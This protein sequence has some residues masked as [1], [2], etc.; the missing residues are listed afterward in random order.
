MFDA[1]HAQYKKL[2]ITFKLVVVVTPYNY[3]TIVN[4]LLLHKCITTIPYND[5]LTM[6]ELACHTSAWISNCCMFL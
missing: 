6:F 2:C 5:I 4:L 1:Y 3:L